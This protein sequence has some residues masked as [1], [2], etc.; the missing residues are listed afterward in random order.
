MASIQTNSRHPLTKSNIIKAHLALFG[1]NT[2]YAINHFVAKGIMPDKLSPTPFVLFRVLGAGA[3]FWFIKTFIK[4]K[5]QKK[6]IFR[7]VLCGLFGASCNQLFFFH[8]LSLTS[9]IDTAIIMTSAPAVVFILSMIALKEK[10]TKSKLIGLS[11]GAIGAL[12]L[13][14]YGQVAEGSSSFSGNLFIFMNVLFYSL[15]QVIVKPLMKTYHFITIISW[16]FLFG[17]VFLI[18]FGIND[19]LYHTNYAL[20]DFN[21]YMVIVYVIV[22][23]TFLTFLFNIYALRYVSPSIAGSYTYVQPAV[24]FIIV[25]FLS[26][27]LGNDTYNDDINMVKLISCFLVIIG[28]YL[29]SKNPKTTT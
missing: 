16:V 9:P 8:G 1:T 4:E 24:S 15:Y 2:I 19:V 23:T 11:I 29:I 17:L 7:L 12:G 6:D 5:I 20:F 25:L 22:F 28:V 21:T 18:P 26:L 13:V 27:A 14:W 3:L 10:I